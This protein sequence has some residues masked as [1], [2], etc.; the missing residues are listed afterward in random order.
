[1]LSW[2]GCGVCLQRVF[3]GTWL[4]Q[5]CPCA[6]TATLCFRTFT[7]LGVCSCKREGVVPLRG[8]SFNNQCCRFLF[9]CNLGLP[10]GTLP[11]VGGLNAPFF[12]HQALNAGLSSPTTDVTWQIPS[13]SNSFVP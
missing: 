5:T 13:A 10:F 6:N 12:V 7:V 11:I 8:G 3:H 1:M 2:G 4:T 9:C